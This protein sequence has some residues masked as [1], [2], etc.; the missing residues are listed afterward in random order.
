M[1]STVSTALL[2]PKS[3]N[4]SPL[5]KILQYV[6][7]YSEQSQSPHRG[8]KALCDLAAVASQASFCC[9]FLA[10]CPPGSSLHIPGKPLLQACNMTRGFLRSSQHYKIIINLTWCQNHLERT[11]TGVTACQQGSTRLFPF[12][13]TITTV[14]EDSPC[15]PGPR[16]SLRLCFPDH[17]RCKEKTATAGGFWITLA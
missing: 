3:D 4:D 9:C 13:G 10:H 15:C 5:I 6:P 17:P 14:Q 11:E 2:E 8:H 7:P 12:G 1:L 16:L